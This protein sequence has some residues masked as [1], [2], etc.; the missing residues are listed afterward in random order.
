MENSKSKTPQPNSKQKLKIYS[1]F[2]ANGFTQKESAGF[3]GVTEKTAKNYET[4]R[5]DKINN[6]ITE[7]EQLIQRLKVRADQP[8]LSTRDLL[9]L[10]AKIEDLNTKKRNLKSDI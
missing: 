4:S 3:A 2:R 8:E 7:L 1:I 9:N 5:I 10:T 6:E